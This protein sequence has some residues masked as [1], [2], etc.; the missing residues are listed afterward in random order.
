MSQTTILWLALIVFLLGALA[1]LTSVALSVRN[2]AKEQKI[3]TISQFE[4]LKILRSKLSETATQVDTLAQ[5]LSVTD[6]ELILIKSNLTT[7]TDELGATRE[8]LQQAKT[9]FSSLMTIAQTAATDTAKVS[10]SYASFEQTTLAD[11]G[12]LRSGQG[13][14][15]AALD[16]LP[17]WLRRELLSI[18]F[19]VE[20]KFLKLSAGDYRKALVDL[21]NVFK[22]SLQTAAV[23]APSLVDL[24]ANWAFF[25]KVAQ[26]VERNIARASAGSLGGILTQLDLLTAKNEWADLATMASRFVTE[27]EGFP[28]QSG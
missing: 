2:T 12:A 28:A 1:I 5:R 10:A 15:Q 26:E 24:S 13:A 20:Y 7:A 16:A 25:Q 8:Q 21:Q 19:A 23:A 9:E 6:D 27:M 3:V 22:G 11:I 17:D 14:V 18:K 4:E